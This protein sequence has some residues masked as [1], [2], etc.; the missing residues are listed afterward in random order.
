MHSPGIYTISAIEYFALPYI[1]KS[2]L[3]LVQKSPAEYKYWSSS[4]EQRVK[5][6]AA[7]LGTMAHT[8]ILEP[9]ELDERV[10]IEPSVD[11]RTKAGKQAYEEWKATAGNREPVSAED[12]ATVMAMRDAVM[13]HKIAGQVFRTGLPERSII[14]EHKLT[15]VMCKSRLDF[16]ADD[17]LV[18]LKTTEN[19]TLEAFQQSVTKYRYHVQVAFYLDALKAIGMD[20]PHNLLVVVESKP[21]HHVA[22]YTFDREAIEEGRYRYEENLRTYAKCKETDTWPGLEETVKT[23]SLPN[24]YWKGI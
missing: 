6:H 23:I 7:A 9:F 5:G 15:G 14:W 3:D 2:T 13:S 4:K 10:V 20:V 16:I 8:A 22:T 12:Y 24:W 1:S 19:A 18:D 11:K 21:P 17:T